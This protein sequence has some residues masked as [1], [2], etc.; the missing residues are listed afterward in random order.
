MLKLTIGIPTYNRANLL[1]EV[2][3]ITSQQIREVENFDVEILV[4]DNASTDNTAEIIKSF[5][6]N[7]LD[8]YIQYHCNKSN[9]GY[10]ENVNKLFQ[11]ASGDYVMTLSDDDGIEPNAIV[12]ICDALVSNCG[13]KIVYIANSFYDCNLE[14]KVCINDP[15]FKNIG[16]SRYF[17]SAKDLFL[18]SREVFG[19]ISGLCIE[20]KS[21]VETN[22][23]K[24]FGTNWIH[25]GAT[26]NILKHADI[27]VITEPIIKYRLD[28]KESRWNSL[29]TSL[30]IQ[31][32]LLEY[33]AIFP[34]VIKG[35]YNE[36]RHQT[37]LSLINSDRS[38]SCVDRNKT[39]S[40]MKMAYDTKKLTFWFVDMPLFYLPSIFLKKSYNWYLH[41]K[42]FLKYI[43]HSK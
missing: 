26:L 22:V 31:R 27:F 29:E 3:Q 13:V 7:N 23:R 41:A 15:F 34:D 17:Q 38:K 24:Y 12:T 36:H 5:Q 21:W 1:L 9:L 16:E 8:I 39:L 25:L 10:D 43:K 20:R 4:S 40:A 2:M 6:K 14:K 35:I 37:R 28:N 33:Y 18:A 30:G 11:L 19:G 42:S 32:I